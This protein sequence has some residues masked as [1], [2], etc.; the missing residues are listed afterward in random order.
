M[1]KQEILAFLQTNKNLLAFSYGSDSTTLFYL[2]HS[3]N[4]EFDLAFVNYKT[5]KES[6]VEEL[7][8]K[9]LALEYN[10][11]IFIKQAPV[12]ESNFEHKARLFRYEFFEELCQKEG[13]T[14]LLMGHQLND[15]FEWFLMQFSK[16]AGLAELLGMKEVEQRKNYTLIRPLLFTSKDEILFFLKQKKVLYFDDES[17]VDEK[18]LRNRIRKHYSNQFITQFSQ[19]VQKSFCYLYRDF[20]K[21]YGSTEIKEIGGIVI[22]RNEES[23]LAKCIK[24]FGIVVSAKQRKELGKGDCVVSGKIAIVYKNQQAFIFKYEH[25]KKLPKA[26]KE[27]YR[28]AQVPKLLRAYLYN[29]KLKPKNVFQTPS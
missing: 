25:C 10:K 29:H 17:N 8:A 4:I 5:R 26:Y 9:K 15:L 18:F 23:L 21:L 27:L 16:G 11:Q 28:K 3:Q 13:Y 22:C 19:G 1:I 2:L 12:F 7:E 24:K 6:D 14:T 20:E